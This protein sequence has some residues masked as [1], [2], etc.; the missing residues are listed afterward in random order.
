VPAATALPTTIEAIEQAPATQ[1]I[2]AARLPAD[3]EPALGFA[4][5]ARTNW[6]PMPITLKPIQMNAKIVLPSPM[7]RWSAR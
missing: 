4:P 6:P 5:R 2:R 3:P 7:T 1:T